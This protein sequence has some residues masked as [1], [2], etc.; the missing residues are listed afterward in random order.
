[1]LDLPTKMTHWLSAFLVGQLIEVNGNAFLS[2]K[3]SLIAGV[4]QSSVLSSL[5]FQICVKIRNPSSLMT[6]FYGLLVKMYNLQQNFCAR[7]YENW[8]S[9]VPNEE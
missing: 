7:T 5:R 6:L 1:M 4:P 9:G 3:I 2:Y 8:Q